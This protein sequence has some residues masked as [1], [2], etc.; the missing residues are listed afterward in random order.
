L[1][2]LCSVQRNVEAILAHITTAVTNLLILL[3][4][5]RLLLLLRLRRLLLLLR[6]RR[7]QS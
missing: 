4:L 6:L 3:R 1:D 2:G 5:R 7:L